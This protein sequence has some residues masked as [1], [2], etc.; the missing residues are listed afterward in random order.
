MYVYII[1]LLSHSKQV[2]FWVNA[3]CAVIFT[4]AGTTGTDFLESC[5]GWSVVL[6]EFQGHFGFS[7]FIAAIW[8]SETVRNYMGPVLKV[9]AASASQ[10]ANKAQTL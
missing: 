3:T 4:T 7:A 8:F 1:H 5:V 9:A 6:P 10:W 2:F